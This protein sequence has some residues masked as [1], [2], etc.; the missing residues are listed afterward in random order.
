M[1]SVA[2]FLT[3]VVI[4]ATLA[5]CPRTAPRG[6]AWDALSGHPTLEHGAGDALV[7][8]LRRLTTLGSAPEGTMIRVAHFG[9]SHIAADLWTGR[10]RAVLQDRFGDGGRGFLLFGKPWDGYWPEGAETGASDGWAGSN[11]LLAGEEGHSTTG[12]FGLGGGALCTDAAGP[13]AWI[14]SSD[15]RGGRY[16]EVYYV[17]G[18]GGGTLEL[19]VGDQEPV[20]IDTGADVPALGVR[21]WRL[22]GDG[23]KTLEVRA[24]GD[25]R[26]CVLGATMERPGTGV[27][28]DSLGLNGARLTHLSRWDPWV[29][30]MLAR[31]GYQLVVFS[32]GTN[33]AID[34]WLDLRTYARAASG[35][36]QRI[37]ALTP[38][39]DC[40]L[41]GPPPSS[42]IGAEPPRFQERLLP[43]VE[44]QKELARRHGC[45][46]FDTLAWTGGP[47]VFQDWL[48]DPAAVLTQLDERL[49]L[50]TARTLRRRSEPAILYQADG[51]HLTVEG[52]RLLGDLVADALLRTWAAHLRGAAADALRALL[53]R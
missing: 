25:G 30:P 28:Y 7:R 48:G 18:P 12:V 27:V 21:F 51:I 10:L 53:G 45:A 33:E 37:R 3:V 8:F 13:A 5:G 39:A 11:A 47:A 1:R 22:D 26:V 46:Y 50:S 42:V 34:E 24:A 2:S 41:V 32:Y 43:L 31:R 49:D 20:S 29:E 52:Y 40:L 4:A 44:L 16:G 14:T 19:T 17:T 35:A 23:P 15:P 9:D 6:A 36:L 38:G